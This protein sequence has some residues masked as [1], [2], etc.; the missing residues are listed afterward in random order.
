[1]HRLDDFRCFHALQDPGLYE[2]CCRLHSFSWLGTLTCAA[3]L[4][5]FG[6][7]WIFQR[8]SRRI[9][10]PTGVDDLC[11]S[12]SGLLQRD[13]R[14]FHF[15]DVRK[16]IRLS[17]TF[18][19]SCSCPQLTESIHHEFPDLSFLAL[20]VPAIIIWL[21]F[22]AGLPAEIVVPTIGVLHSVRRSNLRRLSV[23]AS[24]SFRMSCV[25]ALGILRI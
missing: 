5:A 10:Q 22:G 13:F 19:I 23:C 3:S 1:M 7:S 14:H 8:S 24:S 17:L 15:L 4:T 16:L 6:G 11:C 9:V 18:S 12:I 25:H 21:S 20:G 2:K